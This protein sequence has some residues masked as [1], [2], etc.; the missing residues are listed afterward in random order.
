[1]FSFGLCVLVSPVFA[2]Q[3]DKSISEGQANTKPQIV[4]GITQISDN[5]IISSP[6]RTLPSQNTNVTMGID[7]SL[8][9]KETNSVPVKRVTIMPAEEKYQ[10]NPNAK[11]IPLPTENYVRNPNAQ[12][13]PLP[14]E[15]FVRKEVA[16]YQASPIVMEPAPVEKPIE[17]VNHPSVSGTTPVPAQVNHAS[18]GN[19]DKN[20][21]QPGTPKANAV[22]A[23]VT[24]T[25]ELN[26][27][28]S[29]PLVASPVSVQPVLLSESERPV[30]A[31]PAPAPLTKPL[32]ES[33]R[34]SKR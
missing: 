25:Q 32:T 19:A 6:S 22:K 14:Q 15:K 4:N 9:S 3:G 16:G 20:I 21:Q 24:S 27:Q 13:I 5:T 18:T 12:P 26:R 7:E 28:Q 34:N 1:M 10:R 30:M 33:D 2:Q 23:N 17:Q 29:T 11:P 31:S 8:V